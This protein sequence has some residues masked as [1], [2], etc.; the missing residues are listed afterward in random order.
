MRPM[1]NKLAASFAVL[2]LAA[3]CA[4]PAPALA[5]KPAPAPPVAKAEAKP[6]VAPW[7]IGPVDGWVVVEENELEGDEPMDVAEYEKQVSDDLTVSTYVAAKK[8]TAKESEGFLDMMREQAN[9]RDP[10]L[11]RVLGQR[12]TKVDGHE[13][14]EL[15]EARRITQTGVAIIVTLTV[16]DGKVGYIVSCGGNAKSGDA[17][18]AA[19]KPFIKSFSTGR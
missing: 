13:A 3:G 12:M 14:Y 1:L 18:L 19:C 8:L 6:A 5:P 10:E 15:L 9:G 2:L 16:S 11:V 7:S 4:K 17:V